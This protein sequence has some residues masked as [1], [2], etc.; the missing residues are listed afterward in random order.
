MLSITIDVASS[1]AARWG[2]TRQTCQMMRVLTTFK[3]VA[4]ERIVCPE[5]RRRLARHD[6]RERCRTFDRVARLVE[7]LDGSLEDGSDERALIG[8]AAGTHCALLGQSQLHRAADACMDQ[9]EASDCGLRP[10]PS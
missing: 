7:L 4:C 8:V 5:G 9:D 3:I 6:M 1:S 10:R 2:A